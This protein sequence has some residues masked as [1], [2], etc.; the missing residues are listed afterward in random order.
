M[1][2]DEKLAFARS[3][4][5]QIGVDLPGSVSMSWSPAA[6]MGAGASPAG[7]LL[8]VPGLG[9]GQFAGP[10]HGQ[11]GMRLQAV[12][13]RL[14]TEYGGSFPNFRAVYFVQHRRLGPCLLAGQ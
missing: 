5:V 3:F 7:S 1:T 13:Q 11:L 4:P 12:L 9:C 14:L 2:P 8:T 10:F 6:R